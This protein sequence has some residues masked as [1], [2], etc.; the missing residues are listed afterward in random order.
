[1]AK[2][3]A[4]KAAQ[5][6]PRL[7]LGTRKGVFVFTRK[8]KGWKLAAHAQAGNPI[9]Y[10]VHDVYGSKVLP[11]NL[12]DIAPAT[13]H[14]YKQ[15]LPAD[16]IRAVTHETVSAE[17]LGGASAHGTVSGV[18]HFAC[19]G[20]EECLALIR[21]LLTFLPQNNLEDPPVRPTAGRGAGW[22]RRC[23][24]CW[25]AIPTR[26]WA[27]CAGCARRSPRR[28]KATRRSYEPKMC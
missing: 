2:T 15:R 10:V 13:W 21:E 8:K 18:A 20:E 23:A 12:G 27:S 4:K 19:D 14:T 9:P 11:E 24:S 26:C 5:D 6:G 1:M 7:L 28:P 16:V 22:P 3:T 17:D 25:R